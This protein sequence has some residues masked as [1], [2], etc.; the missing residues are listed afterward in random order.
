VKYVKKK[1][2]EV[3]KIRG[4]IKKVLV[5]EEKPNVLYFKRTI[6]LFCFFLIISSVLKK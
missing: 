1:K 2:E 6:Y 5:Q 3:V 4:K